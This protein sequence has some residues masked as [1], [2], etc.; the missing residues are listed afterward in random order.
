GRGGGGVGLGAWIHPPFSRDAESS[1]RSARRGRSART[2]VAHAPGS[3]SIRR[4]RVAAKL[5]LFLHGH[6][7]GWYVE[8]LGGVVEFREVV[9]DEGLEFVYVLLQFL[10]LGGVFVAPALRGSAVAVL[11]PV[12][13]GG[14]LGIEL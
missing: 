5:G 8:F 14:H 11:D 4:L 12:E 10:G 2:P 6:D 3:P 7:N 13:Q 1:E 9:G